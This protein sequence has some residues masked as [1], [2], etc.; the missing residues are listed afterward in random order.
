MPTHKVTNEII[1]AAIEGFESQKHRI[2]A[3]I[4]ELRRMLDGTR[5]EATVTPEPAKPARKRMSSAARK[6]MAEA[7]RK[8]WAESKQQSGAAQSTAAADV[9]KP[10][11]KLSAAGRRAIAEATRKRW[12]AVRAAKAQKVPAA[13][14]AV[15]KNSAVK[16][17][18]KKTPARKAAQKAATPA[19]DVIQKL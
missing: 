17:S 13:K 2:D 19:Q 7:Q 3:Q 1:T 18:A 11:R 9:I 5:G 4:A 16:K 8:R 10:K 12:A 15:S 14:N 6:R